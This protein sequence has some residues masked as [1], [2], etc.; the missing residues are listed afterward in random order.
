MPA[1]QQ[2]TLMNKGHSCKYSVS[3]MI[4][5]HDKGINIDDTLYDVDRM[6]N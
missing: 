5:V 2:N 6:L 1:N 4:N 3:T